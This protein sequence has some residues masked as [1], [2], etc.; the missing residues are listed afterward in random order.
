MKP[1]RNMT[2]LPIQSVHPRP[3][4]ATAERENVL[5]PLEQRADEGDVQ[6]V[7]GDARVVEG[8]EPVEQFAG[9]RRLFI[10]PL[11]QLVEDA[12]RG[13]EEAAVEIGEVEVDDLAHL[14]RVG[15]GDVVAEA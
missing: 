8:A 10:A 12:Q 4:P 15:K 9:G 3:L 11:A 13:V 1:S 14:L 6:A 7:R 2:F 5:G